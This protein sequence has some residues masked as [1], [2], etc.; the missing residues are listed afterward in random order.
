MS[1]TFHVIDP[2]TDADEISTRSCAETLRTAGRDFVLFTPALLMT[3]GH[4]DRDPVKEFNALFPASRADEKPFGI[5]LKKDNE[6]FFRGLGVH[7]L[8]GHK[9]AVNWDKRLYAIVAERSEECFAFLS[10]IAF[11]AP[12]IGMFA[13]TFAYS[14]DI[15]D[16]T[17]RHNETLNVRIFGVVANTFVAFLRPFPMLPPRAEKKKLESVEDGLRFLQS[18]Q[19]LSSFTG[20]D[21]L[22]EAFSDD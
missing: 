16:P 4:F 2:V 6:F 7:I 11:S 22:K 14:L 18:G 1:K 12:K 8:P 5:D 15:I 17:S 21:P 9:T 3:H 19:F 20:V 13:H 10:G